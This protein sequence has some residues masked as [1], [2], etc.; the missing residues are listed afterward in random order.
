MD[1]KKI[2]FHACKP[3]QKTKFEPHQNYSGSNEKSVEVLD[4]LQD[5]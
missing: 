5:T 4:E 2:T 1:N 3:L